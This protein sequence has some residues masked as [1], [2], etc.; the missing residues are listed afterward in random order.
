MADFIVPMIADQFLN[1][2]K[3]DIKLKQTLDGRALIELAG[4][5]DKNLFNK[6]IDQYEQCTPEEPLVL[7][8]TTT[9]G[10]VTWA[11]LIARLLH[12]HKG[13]VEVRVPRY[14]MSSGTIIALAADRIVLSSV[15]CLGSIDPYFAGINVHQ[16]VRTLSGCTMS[17]REHMPLPN[18]HT[19]LHLLST[20]AE[21]MLGKIEADHT[22]MVKTLFY[23]LYKDNVTDVYD[24][25]AHDKHHDTPIFADDIPDTLGI[26]ISVDPEMLSNIRTRQHPPQPSF[27]D[28][29]NR[30]RMG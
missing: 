15:G 10:G 20:Y 24:F 5:V 29:F 21:T 16:A 3:K 23:D 12:N 27:Q 14:A 18:T 8:I 30:V 4:T 6:L 28:N 25:F 26:N 13:E 11:Y 1:K 22:T 9:G 2:S 17:W 7:E 19:W